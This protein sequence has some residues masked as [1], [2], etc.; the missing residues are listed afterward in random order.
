MTKPTL[1]RRPFPR[2]QDDV[3][4]IASHVALISLV[5]RIALSN[6]YEI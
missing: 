6:V 2:P 1:Q 3:V 5:V 4:R